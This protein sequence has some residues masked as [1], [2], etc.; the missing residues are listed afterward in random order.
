VSYHDAVVDKLTTMKDLLSE[1]KMDAINDAFKEFMNREQN[2]DLEED[3]ENERKTT[4][5]EEKKEEMLDKLEDYLETQTKSM[6]EKMKDFMQELGIE[7]DIIIRLL[8]Q[9][10]FTPEET[11]DYTTFASFVKNYLY[12]L[13]ILLP[14]YLFKG[15]KHDRLRTLNILIPQDILEV[16]KALA[17]KYSQVDA[18]TQDEILTPFLKTATHELKTLYVF[19][20]KYHGFFPNSRSSLYLRF[21]RFS[22]VFVFYYLIVR[23]EKKDVLEM[24]FEH[25]RTQEEKDEDENILSGNN[26]DVIVEDIELRAADK[27]SVQMRVFKFVRALL[28]PRCVYHQDKS[29]LL[30]NY[31]DI[32][33]NVDYFEDEE[34][35]NMMNRF[36]QNKEHKTRR[37]EKDLKKFRIG[38]YFVNQKVINTYGAKR[39]KMLQTN[40]MN[41]EELIFRE[42][43][44][45]TDIADMFENEDEY[46]DAIRDLLEESIQENDLDENG[47]GDLEDDLD[48]NG[49]EAEEVNRFLRNYEDEDYY[50]IA[51]N[52]ADS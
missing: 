48:E 26:D 21:F 37:A 4:N 24:I 12:Y 6:M 52:R 44:S 30:Q 10:S 14:G 22:L 33:D 5:V 51:E 47:E 11:Q 42:K 31:D 39:D 2:G 7:K 9:F 49:E 36:T 50:D 8:N 3:S 28:E 15:V 13:C 17:H 27:G 1:E 18:F 16:N 29:Y 35:T 46:A 41:E 38:Q 23:T 25:I 32:R 34:K 20:S 40:D 19:L 43:R 45:T